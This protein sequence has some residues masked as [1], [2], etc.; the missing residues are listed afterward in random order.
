[1]LPS[2]ALFS[3]AEMASAFSAESHVQQTLRFEAALAR[4][5]ARA[6][7]IPEAAATAIGAACRVELFDVPALYR[8]AALAGTLPI[9]LVRAL[10]ER[11]EGDARRFV[12]WGAT[13]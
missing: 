5:E 3:T 4:A 8:E 7:L 1:M 2:D 6:G 11:L 9:P 12:H 13:T 10:T